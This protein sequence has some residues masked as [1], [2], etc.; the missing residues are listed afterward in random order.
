MSAPSGGRQE[1]LG[2]IVKQTANKASETARIFIVDD[3]PIVRS[4]LEALIEQESGLAVCGGAARGTEALGKISDLEPE[5]ALV[6]ISLEGSNGRDRR[7]AIQKE[8]R[9]ALGIVLSMHD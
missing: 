2:D 4:G 1:N 9:E 5:I 3:H 8:S 7:K 6:D